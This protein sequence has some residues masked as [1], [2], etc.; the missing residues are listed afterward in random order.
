MPKQ[1]RFEV[2]EEGW[3]WWRLTPKDDW[4]PRYFKHNEQIGKMVIRGIEQRPTRD[5]KE[6]MVQGR[7]DNHE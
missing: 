4:E 1:K 6:G 5:S 7:I 2:T 3:Y